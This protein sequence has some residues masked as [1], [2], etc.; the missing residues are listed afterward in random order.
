MIGD[1]RET[2]LQPAMAGGSF[3]TRPEKLLD[4]ADEIQALW[5][6]S[7]V[8]IVVHIPDSPYVGGEITDNYKLYSVKLE[9]RS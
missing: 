4:L 8:E 3:D 9:K 6:G 2:H 7:F 1:Q 5:R